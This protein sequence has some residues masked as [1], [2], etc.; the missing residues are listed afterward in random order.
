MHCRNIQNRIITYS[1]ILLLLVG[2]GLVIYFGFI[3]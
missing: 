3:K 2:I 1:I